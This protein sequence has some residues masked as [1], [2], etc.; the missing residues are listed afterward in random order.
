ML[1]R[2]IKDLNDSILD[3]KIGETDAKLIREEVELVDGVYPEFNNQD[4]LDGK[5]AP[6][7]FGSA[8]NNFGVRELL[9]CFIDIA[10][11]PKPRETE[12]RL[13]KPTEEKMSGF[14]FKI[15]A[16]M[17][18]KH[19]NRIAFLRVCS[20]QFERKKNYYHVRQKKS[21]RFS[22]EIGRAHV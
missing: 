20:G 13:I 2:S 9:D 8:V 21:F 1:F 14:I 12:E 10:P 18:P 3:E 19:R 22:N 11:D 4:Y 17:D 6:V 5:I 16:N 15:H 7:F